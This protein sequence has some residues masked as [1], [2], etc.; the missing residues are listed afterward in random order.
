MS[1]GKWF[2]PRSL[3]RLCGL[4]VRARVVT[5]R[6]VV[7]DI[8]RRFDF[9]SG[10]TVYRAEISQQGRRSRGVCGGFSPPTFEED[11]IFFVF[12]LLY[13]TYK[14][15]KKRD[16]ENESILFKLFL[17]RVLEYLRR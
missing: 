7:G 12:V 2:E 11:D 1:Y 6:T 16:Q 8:D 3:S 13:G 15:I 14:E 9:C 4:I 5:R 17:Q 10:T